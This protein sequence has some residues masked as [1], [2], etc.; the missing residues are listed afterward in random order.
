MKQFFFAWN[1]IFII[2]GSTLRKLN[3]VSLIYLIYERIIYE[4]SVKSNYIKNGR[5]GYKE[6]EEYITR[7][8]FLGPNFGTSERSEFRRKGNMLLVL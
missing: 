5:M 3:T 2:T 7:M 4:R 8:Q 1:S 6:S